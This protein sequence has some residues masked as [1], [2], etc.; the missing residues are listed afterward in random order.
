MGR[1]EGINSADIQPPQ[2][3]LDRILGSNGPEEAVTISQSPVPNE[4]FEYGGQWVTI[5][6][7]KIVAHAESLEDLTRDV[8]Y[9][10]TDVHFLV[11]RPDISHYYLIV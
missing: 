8:V 11:P 6:E 4:A 10:E 2:G 9:S 5:R 7:N 1:H 3:W